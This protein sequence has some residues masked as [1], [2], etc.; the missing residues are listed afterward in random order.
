MKTDGAIVPLLTRLHK[1]QRGQYVSNQVPP[2]TAAVPVHETQPPVEQTSD[3]DIVGVVPR[4][5]IGGIW[6]GEVPVGEYKITKTGDLVSVSTGDSLRDRVKGDAT[7]KLRAWLAPN[8]KGDLWIDGDGAVGG[9]VTAVPR[10]LG[11][12]AEEPPGEIA[13]GFLFPQY[14]EVVG[15]QV[16]D[17]ETGVSHELPPGVPVADGEL[18]R[19]T[20]Y[21]DLIRIDDD[22]VNRVAVVD[23]NSWK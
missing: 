8:P 7:S 10:L 19:L 1:L 5:K 20:T 22:G 15:S 2:P 3:V 13:R 11:Y 18:L 4:P 9:Y 14:F 6:Q 16:R 12:L 23:P 17:I 21:G